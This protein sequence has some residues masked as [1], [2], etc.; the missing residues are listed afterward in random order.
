LQTLNQENKLLQQII[1]H[2]VRFHVRSVL[3]FLLL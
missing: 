2:G 3:L 1:V